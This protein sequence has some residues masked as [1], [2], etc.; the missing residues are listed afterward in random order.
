[1]G[2][3]LG[4]L[5]FGSIVSAALLGIVIL[6]FT[7]MIL[8]NGTRVL[9]IRIGTILT[10]V[11]ITLVIRQLVTITIERCSSPRGFYRTK[12]TMNTLGMMMLACANFTLSIYFAVA[13]LVKLIVIAVLYVG[14]MDMP[15][16]APGVGK[17]GPLTLDSIPV[18]FIKE[19]LATEAH[20]HPYITLMGT[21]YLMKL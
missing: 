9:L 3:L 2:L 14:R 21:F 4:S 17:F 6:I 12:P 7:F 1:M 16:L 20:R 18:F 8:W 15:L 13:R 11:V 5:F 10:G 19:I